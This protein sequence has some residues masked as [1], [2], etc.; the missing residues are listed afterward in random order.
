MP[1][2]ELRRHRE[3]TAHK[4]SRACEVRKANTACFFLKAL[5]CCVLCCAAALDTTRDGGES[6]RFGYCVR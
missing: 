2:R 6:H 1:Q 3:G 4:N 5:S